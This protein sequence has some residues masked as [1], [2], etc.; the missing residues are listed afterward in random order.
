VRGGSTQST[1]TGHPHPSP[2][3]SPAVA[4]RWDATPRWAG[5]P[6]CGSR[7]Q[8]VLIFACEYQN[9]KVLLIIRTSEIK[10]LLSFAQLTFNISLIMNTFQASRSKTK[11]KLSPANITSVID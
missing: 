5:E 2:T 7:F 6:F 3:C 9:R 1:P 10:N 8:G 11:P 4:L